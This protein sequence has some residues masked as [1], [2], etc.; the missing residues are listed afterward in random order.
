[1]R[2]GIGLP[3]S[4]PDRNRTDLAEWA[5]RAEEGPFTS[6]GVIDRL[7]YDSLDPILSL[8]G[9]AAVTSRIRLVTMVVIGPLRP[10]ALLA[11][12]VS[13]LDAISGGRVT[14]GLGLGARLDD[15]QAA[16]A[17]WANRGRH[18]SEQLAT[19]RTIW[20]E[21]G[22]RTAGSR[23]TKPGGPE[24]VVGGASAAAAARVARYADGYVHGGGPPRAFSSAAE[25]VRAA[26]CDAARPGRPS[27]WAQSHVSLSDPEGGEAYLRDYYA[28]AGAFAERVAAGCLGTPEALREHLT[29]YAAAG[30]DELVLLPATSDLAELDRIADV[31]G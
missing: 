19:L 17:V 15:Y 21:D 14:L 24:L 6:L 7:V 29:A 9:A 26:W 12:E 16:G 10:A 23:P 8:A 27:L 25:R 28:F 5:R 30:C 18:L 1:M 2:I 3:T 20:E 31:V 4:T 11:R 13:T 22:D